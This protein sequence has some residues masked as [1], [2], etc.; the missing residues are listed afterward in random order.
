ML[1]GLLFATHE[2]EDRP[3]ILAATLPFAAAPIE[4]EVDASGDEEEESAD[5][6]A[7][8][9]NG[10]INPDPDASA[11]R[12]AREQRRRRDH[13]MKLHQGSRRGDAKANDGMR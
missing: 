11:K 13:W 2:A 9:A 5:Q 1:A 7:Q 4:A 10:G 3:G 8:A 12:Q 6:A